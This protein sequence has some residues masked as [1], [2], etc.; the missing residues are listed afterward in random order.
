MLKVECAARE[1]IPER[2]LI[3]GVEWK[4]VQALNFSSFTTPWDALSFPWRPTVCPASSPDE[5][6]LSGDTG[7][8]RWNQFGL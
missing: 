5:E 1:G 6:G 4:D 3:I 2:D 8:T 7:D